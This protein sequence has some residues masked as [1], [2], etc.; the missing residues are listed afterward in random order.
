M[1]NFMVP[2][3]LAV[4]DKAWAS[5]KFDLVSSVYLS[6]AKIYD[7]LIEL[8]DN[9]GY[10]N[11]FSQENFVGL[12]QAIYVF[13][14]IF[15]LFKVTLAMIQMI[16][17]PDSAT[18]SGNDGGAKLLVRIVT[19]LLML[20]MFTPKGW[21]FNPYNGIVKNLE[22]GILDSMGNFMYG[23]SGEEDKKVNVTDNYVLETVEA[24]KNS[25]TCY[26]YERAS[27]ASSSTSDDSKKDDA[28][29]TVSIVGVHKVIYYSESVSGAKS[30]KCG[31]D[32]CYYKVDTKESGFS[33][34]SADIVDVGS[35]NRTIIKGDNFGIGNNNCPTLYKYDSGYTSKKSMSTTTPVM[36]GFR[37]KKDMDKKIT[38]IIKDK[39]TT[40]SSD[41]EY[42][43]N[44]MNLGVSNAALNFARGIA[45]SFQQCQSDISG[46]S[47]DISK[48]IAECEALQDTMFSPSAAS[49]AIVKLITEGVL[50][51][52]TITSIIVGVIVMVY[53]AFICVEV[54]VR[55]FKLMLLEVL[56]PIPIIAYSDPK[57][58]TFGKWAKMYL[59]TFAELF[60]KLFAIKVGIV[61]LDFV[62]AQLSSTQG[63]LTKF[64]YV[65]GIL[66]FIKVVPDIISEI[67][68]LKMKSGSFKNILDTGKKALGVGVGVPLGAAVGAATAPGGFFGKTAGFVKGGFRGIGGGMKGD[69]FAG[70][71]S[72]AGD[73]KKLKDSIS[74]NGGKPLK[75]TD[76]MLIGAQTSLGLQTRTDKKNEELQLNKSSQDTIK[77]IQDAGDG[78]A[79]SIQKGSAKLGQI[80]ALEARGIF[81]AQ[82][83][84]NLTGDVDKYISANHRY[85]NDVFDENGNIV[86]QKGQIREEN[87]SVTLGQLIKSNYGYNEDGSERTNAE[88]YAAAKKKFGDLQYDSETGQYSLVGKDGNTYMSDGDQFAISTPYIKGVNTAE[89]YYDSVIQDAREN[90][91]VNRMLV[92]VGVNLD[93][94]MKVEVDAD[95]SERMVKVPGATG[96]TQVI[97]TTFDADGQ[98]KRKQIEI[99]RDIRENKPTDDFVKGK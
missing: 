52:D 61:L 88:T 13:A 1:G 74:A 92:D 95:G 44:L 41:D 79:K 68:G 56:A 81:D 4:L 6:V 2:I 24:A 94:A 32:T 40:V 19:S 5:A 58:D 11:L 90:T 59:A 55:R 73:N 30:V 76:R 29:K 57:D 37:T 54:I 33:K 14:G 86:H 8:N 77:A 53:L 62:Y 10:F 70:A 12:S 39:N 36:E 26:Y 34:L 72:I 17:D 43:L 22:D 45:K 75:L 66:L 31:S 46:S 89:A 67:F 23:L 20:I 84:K 85:G 16:I 28:A 51:I 64:L 50:K 71:K 93:A 83:T 7:Y 60:L 15:M 82:T 96:A 91:A 35:F 63:L 9:T 38:A 80:N 48:K 21:I 27:I 3:M 42:I 97:G 78:I 18:K 65:V 69:A 87:F 99:E 49:E 98:L 47:A 25:L